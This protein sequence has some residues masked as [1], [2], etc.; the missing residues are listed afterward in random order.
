MKKSTK[1]KGVQIAVAIV[2]TSIFFTTNVCVP[3]MVTWGNAMA[4]SVLFVPVYVYLDM[5]TIEAN[6]QY[7]NEVTK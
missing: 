1:L 2:G 6:E 4:F 5:K 3:D 7:L